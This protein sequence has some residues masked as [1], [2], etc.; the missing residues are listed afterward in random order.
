MYAVLWHVIVCAVRLAV[1]SS[2]GVYTEICVCTYL[3]AMIH[4]QATMLMANIA[5][6]LVLQKLIVNCATYT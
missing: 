5:V 6:K 2:I 1:C 3:R 4:A